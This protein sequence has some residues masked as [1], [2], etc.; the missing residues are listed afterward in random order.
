MLIVTEDFV[1]GVEQ[2]PV[3]NLG[4][5]TTEFHKPASPLYQAFASHLSTPPAP[6]AHTGG[7]SSRR[8]RLVRFGTL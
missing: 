1:M 5:L 4:G 7:L 2:R 3:I 6:I 8:N